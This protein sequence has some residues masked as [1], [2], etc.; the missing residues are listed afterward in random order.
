MAARALISAARILKQKI[1][2]DKATKMFIDGINNF[3]QPSKF[4]IYRD[5]IEELAQASSDELH[6]L[7]YIPKQ[8]KSL[9]PLE[10]IRKRS[11]QIKTI[12]GYLSAPL[13]ISES[14]K[15]R[16]HG[17]KVWIFEQAMIHYGAV[18]F[19]L[20]DQAET[21]K[22]VTGYIRGGQ[23]LLDISDRSGQLEALPTGNDQQLWSIAA[24]QYLKGTTILSS[25]KWL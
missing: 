4:V 12:Y 7:A 6:A 9:L 1:Y 22:M 14:L 23:E 13:A 10:N 25:A 11:D 3:M 8:F 15:D 18:K 19:G 20:I 21:A 17:N 5:S 16:Y 2:A 24:S